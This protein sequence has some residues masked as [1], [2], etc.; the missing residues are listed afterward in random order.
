MQHFFLFGG[1]AD[2][3]REPNG[4]KRK[5]VEAA[6]ADARSVPFANENAMLCPEPSVDALSVTS[7]EA[8][9]LCWR[10]RFHIGCGCCGC[11]GRLAGIRAR[12]APRRRRT[13]SKR[14]RQSSSYLLPSSPSSSIHH[15]L[16]F[17]SSP[18]TRS[19]IVLKKRGREQRAR[20]FRVKKKEQKKHPGVRV[21]KTHTIDCLTLSLSLSTLTDPTPLI[22]R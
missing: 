5:N 20:S 8:A 6:R 9:R 22:Y 17:D 2:G 19:W 13:N 16:R 15:L 4:A 12:V 14:R 18:Q 7:L 11:Y 3:E 1:H 21:G 10:R